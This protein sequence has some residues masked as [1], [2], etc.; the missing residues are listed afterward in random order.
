MYFLKMRERGSVQFK[1]GRGQKP[2]KPCNEAASI[3][4]VKYLGNSIDYTK[5]HDTGGYAT[6]HVLVSVRHP[7]TY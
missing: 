3:Y 5:L 1:R 4:F 7:I 2:I 6:T